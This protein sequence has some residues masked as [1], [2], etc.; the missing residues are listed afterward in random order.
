MWRKDQRIRASGYQWFDT[1]TCSGQAGSSTHQGIGDDTDRAIGGNTKPAARSALPRSAGLLPS[2]RRA[3]CAVVCR[4]GN[5]LQGKRLRF[6]T[7][8]DARPTIP[9]TPPTAVPRLVFGVVRVRDSQVRSS[10]IFGRSNPGQA[11]SPAPG[12]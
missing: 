4:T 12:G 3:D 5:P 1:S 6:G 10:R 8:D 2:P 11:G 7:P 9:G